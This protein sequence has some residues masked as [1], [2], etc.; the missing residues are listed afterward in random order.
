MIVQRIMYSFVFDEQAFVF[1]VFSNNG[2]P[3]IILLK[4]LVICSK[5]S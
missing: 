3:P 5:I 4:V 2:A 1:L